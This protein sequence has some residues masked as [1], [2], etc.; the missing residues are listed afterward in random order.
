MAAAQPVPKR[1]IR[2]T[3][4]M[5][6]ASNCGDTYVDLIIAQLGLNWALT[7]RVECFSLQIQLSTKMRETKC[8]RYFVPQKN[9]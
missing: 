4:M 3:G 7:Y 1:R 9:T 2:L 6:L 5:G 8:S